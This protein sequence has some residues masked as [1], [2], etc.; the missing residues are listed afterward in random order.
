MTE[1]LIYI[2]EGHASVVQ[3]GGGEGNGRMNRD[4]AMGAILP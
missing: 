3:W 4:G 1:D 2:A